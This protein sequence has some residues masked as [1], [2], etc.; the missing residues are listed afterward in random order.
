MSLVVQELMDAVEG[1]RTLW[2]HFTCFTSGTGAP[3]YTPI[4]ARTDPEH[5]ETMCR[6]QILL[7]VLRNCWRIAPGRS[8][9]SHASPNNSGDIR[10]PTMS[11]CRSGH[12]EHSLLPTPRTPSD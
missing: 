4:L 2:L 3:V 10:F 8:G 6:P 11:V 7:C 9:V 12:T 1:D 5:V